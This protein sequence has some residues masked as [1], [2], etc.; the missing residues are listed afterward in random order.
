MEVHV[1]EHH[2]RAA[3]VRVIGWMAL[4]LIF[5]AVIVASKP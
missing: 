3:K 1:S 4:A 2:I 5:V